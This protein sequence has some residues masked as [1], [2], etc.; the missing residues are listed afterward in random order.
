MMAGDLI[1][2]SPSSD[3]IIPTH[4]SLYQ[5]I[6]QDFDR[7]GNKPAIVSRLIH[8]I[9]LELRLPGSIGSVVMQK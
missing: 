3:V 4:Q 1:V 5:F 2:N 6:C 9:L 8:H 7:Y